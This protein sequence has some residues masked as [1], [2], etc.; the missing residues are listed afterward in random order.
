MVPGTYQR[1]RGGMSFLIMVKVPSDVAAFR[2]ALSAREGEF[3][4]F[5]EKAKVAGAILHRF[6]FGDGYVVAVDEWETVEAY[7]AFFGEPSMRAFI[8]SVGC[9]LAAE[10]TIIVCEAGLSPDQF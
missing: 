6:G 10:P 9:N 5:A 4:S 1:N 3:K 8:E 7:Q 2:R